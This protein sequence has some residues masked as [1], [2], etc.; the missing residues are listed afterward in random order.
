MTQSGHS[1][2]SCFDNRDQ[3]I[4]RLFW[5]KPGISSRP[6]L[7]SRLETLE[8]MANR[9]KASAEMRASAALWRRKQTSH[10][11]RAG[12]SAANPIDCPGKS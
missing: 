12:A 10:S 2:A 6:A 8:V 11:A 4:A 5:S 7:K 3:R 1:K 9:F